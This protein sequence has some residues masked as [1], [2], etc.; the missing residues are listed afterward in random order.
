MQETSQAQ[1]QACVTCRQKCRRCDR[2]KPVCRRCVSKGL[3]C[4]GYPTV[5]KFYGASTTTRK[6]RRRQL[7][8]LRSPQEVLSPPPEP[9]VHTATFSLDEHSWAP[10]FDR[11]P[12][13]SSIAASSPVTDE[14]TRARTV[15]IIKR[16]AESAKQGN[17]GPTPDS[18]DFNHSVGQGSPAAS[19]RTVESPIFTVSPWDLSNIQL[20]DLLADGR[21][22]YLLNHCKSLK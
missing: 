3:E 19:S 5:F 8:P 4:G 16:V 21:T 7:K 13:P 11:S 6:T 12:R 10:G 14:L 22:E 17:S 9:Q 20:E 18:H 1:G 2:A 15:E